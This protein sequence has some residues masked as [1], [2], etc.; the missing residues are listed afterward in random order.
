MKP[1]EEID[2]DV[3]AFFGLQDDDDDDDDDDEGEY[4]I[5]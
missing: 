2:K 1:A 3:L 4:P 5:Q